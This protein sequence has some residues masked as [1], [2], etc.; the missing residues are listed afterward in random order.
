M[1]PTSRGID[2]A[3]GAAGFT[4]TNQLDAQATL[5]LEKAQTAA[6][7]HFPWLDLASYGHGATTIYYWSHHPPGASSYVHRDGSLFVLVGSPSNSVDW[8]TA[9]KDLDTGAMT[10]FEPPWQGRFALARISPDG[11]QWTLWNDWAGSI[12]VYHASVKGVPVAS[13]L[14]PPVVAAAALTANEFSRRGM[15]EML[16]HGHFLGTDTLFTKMQTLPPDSVSRWSG[17]EFADSKALWTV[18]PSDSRWARGWDELAD[19]MHDHTVKV[20]GDALR[21]HDR[22]ILPLS[23]G[24]DSRITAC[25][26]IDQ[27][28]DLH[29]YTYGPATWSE[30]IYARQVARVLGM[31]WQRVD[32]GTS[33]LADYS[34]MWLDWFGTSLHVHGMY[35]MP[36]L[37]AVREADGVILDGWYGNNMAG[38]DHPS[39]GL[40]A[41]PGPAWQG[42]YKGYSPMWSVEE[43]ENLVAFPVSPIIDQMT[44]IVESQVA[45]VANWPYYHQRNAVDMWNRQRNFVFYQPTMYDYWKGVCTPYMDR[46]YARFCLSLPRLALE[47]RRLQVEM[48]KRYYPKVSVIG[49]TANADPPTRTKRH[50]LK[51]FVGRRLLGPLAA[52][53]FRE[54]K[55]TPNTLEADCVKATGRAALWPI[56]DA[57]DQLAEWFNMDILQQVLDSALAGDPDAH[58]K[59]EPI[60][61]IAYR[62]L[63]P[64]TEITPDHAQSL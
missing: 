30:T 29:A 62:L 54:F 9:L 59:Y 56:Y 24:M 16:A 3:R 41:E 15:V 21:Q 38:G 34:P 10:S 39:T 32:L 33:Y 25:V 42:L 26:G 48:L 61:A 18:E 23:G 2:T 7:R 12:P 47:R 50:L 20:V 8:D 60:Q 45:T 1:T 43:L 28:V 13:S 49:T 37:M 17:G 40:L 31:P 55:P 52:G 58:M 51:A 53:P 63:S 14:E 64:P 11:L 4:L 19:E 5:R 6:L 57:W 22:W 27:G 36:F 46:E 35:Q 44:A